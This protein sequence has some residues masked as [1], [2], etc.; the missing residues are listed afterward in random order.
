MGRRSVSQLKTYTGCGEAYRLGRVVEPRPPQKPAAWTAL[1]TALHDV[2]EAWERAERAWLMAEKF[3]LFFDA[4]IETFKYLQPD[5]NEWTKTPRVGSTQRD[6]DLRRLNGI[7]QAEALQ[8]HSENAQWKLWRLPDGSPAVEVPFEVEF[9][10]FDPGVYGEN[11][12]VIRGKIDSI[13][14]WPDQRKTVRDLKSGAAKEDNR[15]LGMYRFAANEL[16][17]LNINFGQYWYAKRGEESSWVDL[18]NYTEEYLTETYVGL[19]RAIEEE[20]FLANPGSQ[21]YL[22]EYKESCREWLK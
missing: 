15:Q 2:Y 7:K 1:G 4:E 6:I 9:E 3:P 10:P 5:L 22:C 14:E 19:D 8:W 18:R 20:I 17:N 21:C 13:L 12:T 11:N 16:F